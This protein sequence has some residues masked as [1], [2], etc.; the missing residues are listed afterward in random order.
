MV[1]RNSEMLAAVKHAEDAIFSAARQ[2]II[3]CTQ[4]SSAAAVQNQLS[5]EWPQQP[6]AELK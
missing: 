4:Y 3:S 5:P 6:K 1:V 2:R